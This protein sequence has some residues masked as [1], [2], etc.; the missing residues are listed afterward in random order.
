MVFGFA[1]Q[2]GGHLTLYSEIGVGTTVKL[3][4]PRDDRAVELLWKHYEVTSRILIESGR[5]D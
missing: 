5:F 1:K 4:L 2:S 3:Y